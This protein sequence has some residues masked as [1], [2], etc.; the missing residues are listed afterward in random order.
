MAITPCELDVLDL[1]LSMPMTHLR[2]L[3]ILARVL[4]VWGGL[5]LRGQYWHGC[6]APSFGFASILGCRMNPISI[7]FILSTTELLKWVTLLLLLQESQQYCVPEYLLLSASEFFFIFSFLK[8][9]FSLL[10]SLLSSPS[11]QLQQDRN[12]KKQ[13][14]IPFHLDVNQSM[15]S[16]IFTKFYSIL[17]LGYVQADL[18]LFFFSFCLFVCFG[19][20]YYLMKD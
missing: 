5:E 16:S 4:L 19:K 3:L 11:L 17:E 6:H 9:A 8:I 10:L 18:S 2:S 13:C 1:P 7:S 15:W 14:S 20:S 12:L